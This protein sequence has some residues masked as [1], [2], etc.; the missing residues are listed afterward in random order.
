MKTEN[1]LTA[2]VTIQAWWRGEQTRAKIHKLAKKLLKRKYSIRELIETEEKYI[3]DLSMV[4]S[5]FKGNL[6]NKKI[7]TQ[8]QAQQLFCNIDEI[9]Q[10]NE[11][12]FANIFSQAEQYSHHKIIF[13]KVEKEIPFFKIYFEYFNNYSKANALVDSLTQHN[14]EFKMF[15]TETRANPKYH[16]LTLKDFL[17]KPVQRLPKYVL[18]MREIK[19]LTP[20]EHPDLQNIEK[21]L[22][23]FEQVNHSNNNKL[24]QVLNI[25]KVN[26]I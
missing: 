20:L 13:A 1:E 18:L 16:L 26:E 10:L 22:L 24:N 9:R 21:V 6:L 4:I 5:D 3:R 14:A 23:T 17:I 12:F 8:E 11:L 19:K 2:V 7:I 15:L 25:H